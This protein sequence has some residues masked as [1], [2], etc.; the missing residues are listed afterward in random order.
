LASSTRKS[1]RATISGKP[2]LP[3][4]ASHGIWAREQPYSDKVAA[5]F[6]VEQPFLG[7]SIE[8]PA[9]NKKNHQFSAWADFSD[10][11]PET[12]RSWPEVAAGGGARW[13]RA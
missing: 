2:S 7:W 8:I 6:G 13:R 10:E 3:L 12:R 5:L 11:P 4:P 9:Q 1:D